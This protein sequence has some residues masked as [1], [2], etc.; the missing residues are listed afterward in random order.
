M[1]P[2]TH[3]L[4][5]K[6]NLRISKNIRRLLVKKSW[7]VE[8]LGIEADYDKSN[9]YSLMGGRLNYTVRSMAALAEALQVDIAEFFKK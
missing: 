3:K 9:L 7:T 6:I 2:K 1:P 4:N 5:D 8:R